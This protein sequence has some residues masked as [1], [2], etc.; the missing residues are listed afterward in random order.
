MEAQRGAVR[1]AA[2]R[3]GFQPIHLQGKQLLVA[4]VFN[5]PCSVPSPGCPARPGGWPWRGEGGAEQR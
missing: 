2:L 1:C 3:S 4:P 5:P